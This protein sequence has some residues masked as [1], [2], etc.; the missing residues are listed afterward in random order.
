MSGRMGTGKGCAQDVL[1]SVAFREAIKSGKKNPQ[2][3]TKKSKRC[4]M[5]VLKQPCPNIY[6]GTVTTAYH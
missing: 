2:G 3:E 6:K 4:E 5:A 1:C